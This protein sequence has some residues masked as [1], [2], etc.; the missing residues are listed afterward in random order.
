MYL[1][2]DSSIRGKM[3]TN[4]VDICIAKKKLLDALIT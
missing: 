2:E 1:K 4:V 3:V